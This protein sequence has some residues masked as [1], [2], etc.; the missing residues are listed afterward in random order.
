MRPE[1]GWYACLR[2]PALYEAG[3]SCDEVWSLRLLERGVVAQPGYFFDFPDGVFLV[4]SLIT[5]EEEFAR[6]V[7]VIARCLEEPSS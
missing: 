5:P 3:L 7:D 4:L 2:M 6:G 1:G